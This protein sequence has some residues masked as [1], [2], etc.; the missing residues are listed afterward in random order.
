M[1]SLTIALIRNRD[2]CSSVWV[3]CFSTSSCS[4]RSVRGLLPKDNYVNIREEKG[5][6]FDKTRFTRAL[7]KCSSALPGAITLML[8]S[9]VKLPVLELLFIGDCRSCIINYHAV[10]TCSKLVSDYPSRIL[11]YYVPQQNDSRKQRLAKG[12]CRVASDECR[13]GFP[14]I[15]TLIHMQ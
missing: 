5:Y 11:G 9:E 8:K 15:R 1:S 13:L 14:Q 6:T 4:G 3:V 7:I 2:N 12:Y 10:R